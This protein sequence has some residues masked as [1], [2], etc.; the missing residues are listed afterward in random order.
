MQ[1]E[2]KGFDL[3]TH[4][5]DKKGNIAEITPYR[6]RIVN[7]VQRFERPVGSGLWYDAQNNLVDKTEPTIKQVVDPAVAEKEALKARIA[8]LETLVKSPNVPSV[9]LDKVLAKEPSSKK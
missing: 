1:E 4:H 8:E 9:D 2:K 6:L 3:V 7:G 5:R